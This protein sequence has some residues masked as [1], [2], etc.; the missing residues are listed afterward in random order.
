MTS[1]P[2]KFSAASESDERLRRSSIMSP[3]PLLANAPTIQ[4]LSLKHLPTIDSKRFMKVLDNTV[5]R[6]LL[7]SS[8]P[9]IVNNISE[10]S[11]LLG[12]N[13]T[14]LFETYG[15]LSKSFDEQCG[16]GKYR[17]RFTDREAMEH[18]RYSFLTFDDGM[19]V[20]SE[21]INMPGRSK[22]QIT[23]RL[24]EVTRLLLREMMNNPLA[25]SALIRHREQWA[26]EP[27]ASCRRLA[28]QLVH[29]RSLTR[30]DLLTTPKARARRD[31]FL[32]RLRRR[33]M[34]QKRMIEELTKQFQ[35]LQES[36]R[37]QLV[38][39]MER[40]KHLQRQIR[41]IQEKTQNELSQL[42]HQY[43]T[44]R[45]LSNQKHKESM[46]AMELFLETSKTHLKTLIEQNIKYERKVRAE[47][48]KV[49]DEI[50]NML[51]KADTEMFEMQAEYDA[52]VEE[53]TKESQECALLLEKL[54][55]LKK[56]ADAVLEEKRLEAER[57]AAELAEQENM[58]RAA[59]TIQSLWRSWKARKMI[60]AERRRKKVKN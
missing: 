22:P 42:K 35:T 3:L 28:V 48:W 32:E 27:S 31:E 38:E 21:M 58:I 2:R 37:S 53:E 4:K 10:F 13:A 5:T 29:L 12:R 33:D 18:Q 36:Q 17:P 23:S 34:E 15:P 50:S 56:L 16:Q 46:R 26:I 49:E 1:Q 41:D 57:Q 8:F 14:V 6:V 47:K 60:K 52:R 30:N 19:S 9:R 40:V 25:I 59:T 43:D 44:E 45:H 11:L 24:F 7:V 55:P 20:G 39:R 54:E 51:A